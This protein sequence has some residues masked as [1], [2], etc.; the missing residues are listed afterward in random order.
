[1]PENPLPPIRYSDQQTSTSQ[2]VE[3]PGGSPEYAGVPIERLDVAW[4]TLMNWIVDPATTV[5]P[6]I[7]LEALSK[8]APAH[9]ISTLLA[10]ILKAD[11]NRTTE[12]TDA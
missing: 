12:A 2:V 11:D 4:D 6:I 7:R 1:M 10:A 5:D 9:E 8:V 3:G